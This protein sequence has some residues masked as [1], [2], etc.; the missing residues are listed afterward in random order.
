MDVGVPAARAAGLDYLLW[1]EPERVTTLMT[2][3]D[4]LPYSGEKPPVMTSTSS[5]ASS[6]R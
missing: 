4:T 5:M 3:P 6:L 2:P 1:F